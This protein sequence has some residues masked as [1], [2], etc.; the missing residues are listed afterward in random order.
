M[1]IQEE[2]VKNHKPSW[3]GMYDIIKKRGT[4]KKWPF[5]IS[6]F[7]GI[8]VAGA[9]IIFIPDKS[10]VILQNTSDLFTSVFPSLLGFALGGYAIVIGFSNTDLLKKASDI[11]K[12]SIYQILSAI[13]ALSLVFQVFT[14]LIAFFTSW[15]YK[16]GLPILD[17][18]IYFWGATI[19]NCIVILVLIIG[20]I[21]SLILLPYVVINL[22][23]LGQ[24]SNMHF[25]IENIQDEKS[26]QAGDKKH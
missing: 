18:S 11:N 7:L 17:K 4:L 3:K 10:Y 12:H 21:Y 14:T 1:R 8:I 22:F 2:I 24:I 19:I 23:S 20:A 25:T 9:I 6:L 26:Q 5:L 16:L 15:V 13:F